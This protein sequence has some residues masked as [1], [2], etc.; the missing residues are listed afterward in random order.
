[1]QT[2]KVLCARC[3]VPL[4]GPAEPKPDDRFAC[5]TCGEG[6]KFE[7]VFAEVQEYVQEM[8]A[9]KIAETVNKSNRAASI[10]SMTA[11]YTPCRNGGIFSL[12]AAHEFVAYIDES[13]DFLAN[14]QKK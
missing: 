7:T 10:I 13:G 6:D 9:Q 1:M 12:M 3:H 2:V 14:F 4:E 11:S 5:P 8:T